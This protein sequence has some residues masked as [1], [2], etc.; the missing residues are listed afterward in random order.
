MRSFLIVGSCLVTILITTAAH[1]LGAA[2]PLRQSPGAAAPA[3]ASHK[4]AL[5][6]Y[7]VTCHNQRLRT[8]GF[9]LDGLDMT[10]ASAVGAQREVWEKV[11]HKLRA[12]TMPPAGRPRRRRACSSAWAMIRWTWTRSARAPDFRPSRWHRGCCAWSSTAT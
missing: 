5:D 11:I 4:A 8:A 6:K 1:D 3:I 12:R 10:S 9:A 7:C 2:A